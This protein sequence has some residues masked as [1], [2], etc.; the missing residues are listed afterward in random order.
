MV[1]HRK[2]ASMAQAIRRA[3]LLGCSRRILSM[4]VCNSV[5][6]FFFASSKLLPRTVTDGLSQSPFQPSSSDQ[7]SQAMGMVAVTSRF[8]T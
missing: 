1:A 7:K 6:M 4:C 3:I 2:F 8:T 5:A